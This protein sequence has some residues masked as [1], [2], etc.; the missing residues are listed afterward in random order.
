MICP[1]C[2]HENALA[3]LVCDSCA[4]D[5]AVP[6]SLLAERDELLGKR[7]ILRKELAA[8]SA[9]VEKLRRGKMRRSA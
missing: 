6:K 1:F 2:Q 8:A 4:R 7:D 9:E 5:I 3:A